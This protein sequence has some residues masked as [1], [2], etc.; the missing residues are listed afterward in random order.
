[1]NGLDEL[2]SKYLD[3]IAR[4]DSEAALEELR[5]AAL[6]KKGE[7]LN[8]DLSKRLHSFRLVYNGAAL[9][10]ANFCAFLSALA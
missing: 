5:V 7:M 2:K 6:G 1:M 9:L 4:A 10:L 3:G 8:E